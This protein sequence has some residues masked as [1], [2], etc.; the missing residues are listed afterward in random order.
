[1]AIVRKEQYLEPNIPI[2]VVPKCGNTRTWRVRMLPHPGVHRVSV[3]DTALLPLEAEV[4]GEL[5][6]TRGGVRGE[7]HV[8]R[9][10]VVRLRRAGDGRENRLL[11]LG[12][13]T[14]ESG[15]Q[16]N[17]ILLIVDGH[18][19]LST[20]CARLACHLTRFPDGWYP[21]TISCMQISSVRR[22]TRIQNVYIKNRCSRPSPYL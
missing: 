6:I 9:A 7:T 2:V 18:D 10:T 12:T 1:M 17:I 16:G 20:A 13:R 8:R 11:V 5:P 14:S 21:Y 4:A 19:V 3:V 15:L 22:K